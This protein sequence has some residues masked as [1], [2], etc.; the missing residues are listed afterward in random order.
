MKIVC[1]FVLSG[2][3]I[4]AA[5]QNNEK[6]GF[7]SSNSWE[8]CKPFMAYCFWDRSDN[9]DILVHFISN[10]M[11]RTTRGTEIVLDTGD[12]K[13]INFTNTDSRTVGAAVL[14][15]K[16][17]TRVREINIISYVS[18][19]DISK[20]LRLQAAD[21]RAFEFFFFV[22]E[23]TKIDQEEAAL[24][25]FKKYKVFVAYHGPAPVPYY[26]KS[27]ATDEHHLLHLKHNIEKEL[28]L[29]ENVI[30]HDSRLYCNN[31]MHWNGSECSTCSYICTQTSSESEYCTK[32]CPY[33][34]YFYSAEVKQTD[35]DIKFKCDCVSIN[36]LV[37][38]LI[39]LGAIF[40]LLLCFIIFNQISDHVTSK[41]KHITWLNT[42]VEEETDK[43]RHKDDSVDS[44]NESTRLTTGRNNVKDECTQSRKRKPKRVNKGKETLI[45]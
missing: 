41:C 42:N 34:K 36:E 27:L 14:K 16:N 32:E 26:W 2:M 1:V 3:F 30:C 18:L 4:F 45:S 29:F 39:V 22:N 35:G 28:L 37:I 12:S 40:L 21:E 10:V 33:F 23:K 11:N 31:D 6:K 43:V 9:D 44:E 20:L 17:E 5:N 25:E 8:T 24:K 38:A 13:K 19:N 7:L 15:V